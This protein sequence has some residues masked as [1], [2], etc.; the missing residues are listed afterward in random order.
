MIQPYS[1]EE[2]RRL[3]LALVLSVVFHLSLFISTELRDKFSWHRHK[4]EVTRPADIIRFDLVESE[5]PL[6]IETPE[7]DKEEINSST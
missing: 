3:L 4:E 5:P 6:V 2:H 1:I 7:V